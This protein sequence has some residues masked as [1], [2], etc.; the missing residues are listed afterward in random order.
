MMQSR[1]VVGFAA[2]ADHDPSI[3]RA[4]P[5][6]GPGGGDDSRGGG[7]GSGGD[8]AGGGDGGGGGGG[9]ALAGVPKFTRGAS[10]KVL[11]TLIR[12]QGFGAITKANRRATVCVARAPPHL[13]ARSCVWRV[14]QVYSIFFSTGMVFI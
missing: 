1:S 6:S 9:G 3:S 13:F 5:V 4:A 11:G 2:T 12:R 14:L 8:S 10:S 7:A